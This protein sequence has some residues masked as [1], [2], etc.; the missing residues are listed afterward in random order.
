MLM[1]VSWSLMGSDTGTG[2]GV[3]EWWMVA[4]WSGGLKS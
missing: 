1:M 3:L 2:I 4:Y